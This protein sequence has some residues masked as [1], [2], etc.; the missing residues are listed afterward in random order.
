[1]PLVSQPVTTLFSF[2]LVTA[3]FLA[4]ASG[5]GTRPQATVPYT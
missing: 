2:A 5:T 1:M 4:T 3:E